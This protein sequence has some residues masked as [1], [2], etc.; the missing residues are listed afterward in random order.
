[1]LD[2]GRLDIAETL[3]GTITA[4]AYPY[5]DTPLS[6]KLDEPRKDMPFL[7]CL[8]LDVL[9]RDKSLGPYSLEIM[10]QEGWGK[11]LVEGSS[12][13]TA[14]SKATTP[15]KSPRKP[16]RTISSDYPYPKPEKRYNLRKK[17]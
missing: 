4:V 11:S 8:T 14:S 5:R 7:D 9:A 2:C 1:M 3:V 13:K 12:E 6:Q 15:R 16:P 10:E 17:S